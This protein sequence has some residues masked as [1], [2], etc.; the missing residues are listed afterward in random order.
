MKVLEGISTPLAAAIRIELLRR[1][2]A[3]S[4]SRRPSVVISIFSSASVA[5]AVA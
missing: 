2:A 5:A 1:T 4:A 3:A